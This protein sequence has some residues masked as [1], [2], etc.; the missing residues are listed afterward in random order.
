MPEKDISFKT[1]FQNF[2]FKGIVLGLI[3]GTAHLITLNLL[4]RKL[5]IHL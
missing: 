4:K 3:T 1:Y 2:F 5:P